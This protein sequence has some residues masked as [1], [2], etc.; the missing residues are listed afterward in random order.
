MDSSDS[1]AYIPLRQ[2]DWR[3]VGAIVGLN[4]I[5]LFFYRQLD[6]VA[7]GLTRS[8]L[9]TFSEEAIGA[10]AGFAVFPL[11]YL[12]AIHFPL[13]SKRWRINMAAH[14]AAVCLISILHT[15]I[16]AGLRLLLFPLLGFAGV[17]YGYLPVRYP[18]EFSHFFIY[19]GLSLVL[20]YLFHEVRFARERELRSA[21]L[22]STL[23]EAQLQNLRLQLEPHFLFNTLNA[24]SAALYEDVRVADEMIGR[25]GELLRQLLKEDRSQYVSLAREMEILQLYTRIM[26]ARFE[27]RLTIEID[28]ADDVRSA[29][30]PQLIFQPL[31]ENAIRHGMDEGFEASIM[32]R[33]CKEGDAL[34]L[35]VRD[36][37]PGIDNLVPLTKGIGLRNT[38]E[39]LERLYGSR[40]SFAIRNAE[41]GGAIVEIRLPLAGQ[42]TGQL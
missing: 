39:R 7:N 33:A 31:V 16:I 2:L 9:L 23:A 30:V 41:S 42:K 37:G 3:I 15:S 32:I 26:Q 12:A 40:Q 27:E 21:K 8:P 20:I 18:M 14:L 25:L 24:I 28:L 29:L 38:I 22:E 19:Y 6:Y 11:V 34:C 13:L 35:S 4:T 10:M 5:C 1:K 17:G 36:H